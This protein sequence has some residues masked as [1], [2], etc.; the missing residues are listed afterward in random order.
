MKNNTKYKIETNI[1]HLVGNNVTKTNVT[2]VTKVVNNNKKYTMLYSEYI[3]KVEHNTEILRNAIKNNININSLIGQFHTYDHKPG[4]LHW[5][6]LAPK[7][8]D[9]IPAAFLGHLAI[10][11]NHNGADGIRFCQDNNE[12]IETEYKINTVRSEKIIIGP[13]GGMQVPS[14]NKNTTPTGIT[15]YISAKFDI[16]S[17]SNLVTKNRETYLCLTD[18]DNT[19][20]HFIDFW[21]LSGE[22]ALAALRESDKKSRIISLAKFINLGN[23]VDSLVPQYTWTRFELDQKRKKHPNPIERKKFQ[24]LHEILLREGR[25]L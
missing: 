16:H 20:K 19:E 24:R 8:A 3:D 12:Y 18:V 21:K 11:G 4:E 2:N 17:A 5:S 14:N 25:Y 23:T 1:N 6:L 9:I 15:S 10:T 22:D 13:K 7:W